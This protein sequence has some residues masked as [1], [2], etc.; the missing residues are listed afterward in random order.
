[1]D[2]NLNKYMCNYCSSKIVTYKNIDKC[3][4]CGKEIVDSNFEFNNYSKIIPFT[5]SLEDAKKTYKKCV[6]FN[7]LIP[8]IFKNQNTVNS[9]NKVYLPI[10]L[11]KVNINGKVEFLGKNRKDNVIHNLSYT[12]NFDYNNVFIN[13]YSNIDDNYINNIYDYD[14]SLLKDID[15]NYLNDIIFIDNISIDD[16]DK[17]LNKKTMNYSLI[18]IRDNINYDLKKLEKN[19]MVFTNRASFKVF[20]PVYLLNVE[21]KG[22]KYLFL[23]N[24]V[25]GKYN[26]SLTMSIV[27]TV[28][29]SIIVFSLIVLLSYLFCYFF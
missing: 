1:M 2:N 17:K 22:K 25:S 9:I 19:D 4:Y 20:V 23:M 13:T 28:I 11:N 15:S 3:P 27:S 24:G 6:L 10:S 26:I 18:T 8:L 14:F 7:P 5:K 21:Y 16:I 12:S 29:F